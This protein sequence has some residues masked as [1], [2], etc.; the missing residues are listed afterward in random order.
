[1]KDNMFHNEV[2]TQITSGSSGEGLDMKGSDIDIKNAFKDV[3]VYENI[4]S[5][6]FNTVE[7]CV[8]MEMENNKLGFT[9]Q[10]LLHARNH[11]ILKMC[12]QVGK[13]L[14]LSSQL[15]KSMFIGKHKGSDDVH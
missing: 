1:M 13:D 6:R 7:T 8:A 4:N 9:H 12:T 5:T 10:R 15:C 2:F 14:Y 11:S 3:N